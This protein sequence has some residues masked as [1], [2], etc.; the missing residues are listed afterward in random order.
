[1][2]QNYKD[3]MAI[4]RAIGRPDLFVTMTCNPSWPELNRILKKFPVG[5][6]C[7]DIPNIT[8]RLFFCKLRALLAY[9]TSGK[10]FRN[11]LAYVYTIEFRKRGLPHAHILFV[12]NYK[13]ILTTPEM[14]DKYISADILSI[15]FELQQLV[16]KHMLHGPHTDYSPCYNK[17]KNECTKKFPKQFRDSTEFE[18]NGFPKYRRRDNKNF[19][20]VY[21][22][23]VN[24][25]FV[26]VDN[27]MVVPYNPEVLEKYKCHIRGV[28]KK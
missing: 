20:H 14:I 19:G 4:V 15:D 13:N 1:M 6:T 11:I 18:K 23:K 8:V 22:Q 16:I 2:H 9:I 21:N 25:D 10:I 12:L 5:T 17:E 3:A 24:R 28:F 7:N 26:T 27:S